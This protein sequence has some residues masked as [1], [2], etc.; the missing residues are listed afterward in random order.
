MYF[1][2]MILGLVFFMMFS[3]S[4]SAS[5]FTD[6][7]GDVTNVQTIN[8]GAEVTGLTLGQNSSLILNGPGYPNVNAGLVVQPEFYD[9]A[10]AWEIT[11][12]N[13]LTAITVS[14][15]NGGSNPWTEIVVAILSAGNV[16]TGDL[17]N[18]M[19]AAGSSAMGTTYASGDTFRVALFGNLTDAAKTKIAGGKTVQA[20]YELNVSAVPVP[21]AVWL[22]GTAIFGLLGFRKK[23]SMAV[24]AA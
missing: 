2:K 11:T 22:F 7:T 20:S 10:F 23:A 8:I 12:L 6:L 21:A 15:V 18:I 9:V 13:A 17:L 5:L 14:S 19:P 4:A 16:L 1:R 3:G 24:A